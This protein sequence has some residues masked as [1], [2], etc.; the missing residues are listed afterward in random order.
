MYNQRTRETELTRDTAQICLNGHTINRRFK[1]WPVKNSPH[2]PKCG[3]ATITQCP[4]CKSDLPGG[5]IGGM[6]SL[7]DDPPDPF[8][9]QCGGAYPWTETSL[10]AAREYIRE[11]DRLNDNEKGVL[12]RSLDDLVRETPNTPVAILRFKQL[13]SKAGAT[14]VDGLKAI[15]VQIAVESA[16]QQIWHSK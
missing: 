5:Y 16:K 1:S 12:S 9:H 13:A 14:A 15:L 3:A 10:S 8:C 7:T 2:C 4:K 6:P 11:L